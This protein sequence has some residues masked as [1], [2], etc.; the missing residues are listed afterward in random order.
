MS[1]VND[2]DYFQENYH[3]ILNGLDYQFKKWEMMEQEN[4][5][6]EQYINNTERAI[7]PYYNDFNVLI[8]CIN[9]IYMCIINF[10]IVPGIFVDVTDTN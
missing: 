4:K 3:N 2:Y 9:I 5:I 8:L 6:Y 7:V 1:I 10:I